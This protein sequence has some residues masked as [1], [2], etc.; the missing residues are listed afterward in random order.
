MQV[1]KT[2]LERKGDTRKCVIGRGGKWNST[3]GQLPEKQ[4]SGSPRAASPAHPAGKKK[5]YFA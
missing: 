3:V 5:S 1:G 2:A 4:S